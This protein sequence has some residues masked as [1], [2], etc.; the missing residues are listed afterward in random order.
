MDA[1]LP[2]D[3]PLERVIANGAY[4]SIERTEALSGAGVTPVIP[5]P[6]HAVVHGNDQT[7][8][9]DQIV[10]YI[11]DKGIYAFQK[12]T[13]TGCARGSKRRSHASSDALA[14]PP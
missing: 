5:P 7:R 6:A 2:A 14:L 1:V 11:E 9:H 12:N 4:Y 8:W 13:A 3:V 10:K